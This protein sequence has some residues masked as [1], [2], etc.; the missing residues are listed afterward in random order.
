MMGE[1]GRS[2]YLLKLVYSLAASWYY[3]LHSTSDRFMAV[4]ISML[5]AVTMKSHDRILD[6]HISNWALLYVAIILVNHCYLR[7]STYT[8]MQ[9]YS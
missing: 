4:L 1:I 6:K 8:K 7:N 3:L 5:S 2:P 9:L